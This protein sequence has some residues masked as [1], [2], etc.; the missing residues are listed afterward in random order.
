MKK[1][2]TYEATI[3]IQVKLKAE[4]AALARKLAQATLLG[5]RSVGLD[6][7]VGTARVHGGSLRRVSPP[8]ASKGGT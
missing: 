5:I 1:A 2:Y 3:T 7:R 8:P 6:G 4:G